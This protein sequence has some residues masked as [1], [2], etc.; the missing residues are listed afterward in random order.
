MR[1]TQLKLWLVVAVLALGFAATTAVRGDEGHEAL[2]KAMETIN[3]GYKGLRKAAR[4]KQF[5]PASAKMVNAMAQ[6]AVAAIAEVPPMAKDVP[7]AERPKFIAE[8]QA[9]M[10]ELVM[11]LIDLQIAIASGSN[12]KAAEIVDALATSKKVGHE[13]FTKE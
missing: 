8:Y 2:E 4:S 11:Q 12:D 13:K 6:A 3:D 7:T 9:S 10:K 1:M 5:D